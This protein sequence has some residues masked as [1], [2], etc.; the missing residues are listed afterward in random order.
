MTDKPKRRWYQFSLRGL[1]VVLTLLCLGPGG[2]VAY[3]QAKARRQ[4]ATVEAIKKLGGV[5]DYASR[6]PVRSPLIRQILADDWP[7]MVVSLDPKGHLMTDAG[8]VHLAKLPSL[9]R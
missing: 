6:D 8:W 3:E 9:R 2:Y 4:T 5:F 1:L 7:G